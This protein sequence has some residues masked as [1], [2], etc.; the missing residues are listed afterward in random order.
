MVVLK[1]TRTDHRFDVYDPH[2]VRKE[3]WNDGAIAVRLACI[4]DVWLTAGQLYLY[5]IARLNDTAVAGC[6]AS[7]GSAGR[8]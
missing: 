7:R 4:D 2:I 5:D 8:L 3:H 1:D 6:G